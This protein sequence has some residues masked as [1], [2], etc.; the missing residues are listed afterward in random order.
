M[1]PL[2]VGMTGVVKGRLPHGW[3]IDAH[4]DRD[5][6]TVKLSSPD[7]DSF[8]IYVNVSNLEEYN[9]THMPTTGILENARLE[10]K[11]DETSG[12]IRY[13]SPN[14]PEFWLEVHALQIIQAMT[15][16]QSDD[17]SAQSD[18]TQ[19]AIMPWSKVSV[20]NAVL[21][22]WPGTSVKNSDLAGSEGLIAFFQKAFDIE[23]TP[24]GCVETLPDQDEHGVEVEGTGGRHDFFFYIKQSDIPK[25]AMRRFAFGMRWWSDV[26]FNNGED[27]YPRDFLEA[28][29]E[30]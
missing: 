12:I 3:R 11:Y 15:S 10:A 21:T 2:Q 17:T 25:F 13:D 1:I 7:S 5:A 29:P 23:V 14:V 28:Y 20:D 30:Q 9:S 8:L 24:V 19:E 26:Y 4:F 27:I 22:L 6:G 16:A 18:G